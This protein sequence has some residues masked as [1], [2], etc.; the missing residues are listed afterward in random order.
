[1]A[2]GSGVLS[3]VLFEA[4]QFKILTRHFFL[5]LFRND[6]VD[7]E[8]QMKERVIGILALLAVFSGLLAYVGLEKYLYTPD[9]GRSWIEKL[10][11][12]TFFMLIMGLVSILEWEVIYPDRRDL[13]NLGPLP[14]KPR[15]F[16]AAKFGSLIIFVGLFALSLN[17]LSSPFFVLLLPQW[18]SSSIFFFLGHA[19]V[20]FLVMFLA[21]FFGFLVPIFIL[22]FLQKLMGPR[23]FSRVSSYLRSLLLIGQTF[24]ILTYLRILVYGLNNL[25]V[26]KQ[27]RSDFS[28]AG[29]FFD[30]FPPFWFTDLYETVLGRP[31]LPFHGRY[32]Y[33]LAGLVLMMAVFILTMG[34]TY[35][36]SLRRIEVVGRP[37]L[38]SLHRLLETV[39]NGLFLRNPVE[40]A[41]FHFFRKTLKLSPFHK[42]RL[43]SFLACGIALVPFLITIKTVQKD[44]LFA[45]N[46]TMLS[47]PLILSFAL[48][49]G[50]RAVINVPVSLEANW[51]FRLTEKYATRPY[52]SG[53]RKAVFLLYLVPLFVL[54][55]ALYVVL[56]DPLTAIRHCLYGLTVSVLVMEVFFFRFLK[57][58]FACAYLPGKEKIQSYW[59]IYLIGF[60]A[61]L[62][63]ASR[64]ELELLRSPSDFIYFYGVAFLVFIGIR[65]YQVFFLY[66]RNRIQYE[67]Q[68]EPVMIG[69]DYKAPPHKDSPLND[70]PSTKDI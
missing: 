56:W 57:I 38:R 29:R 68:L 16:L 26:I 44:D 13:S 32:M 69:L 59:F 58:P 20:H 47:I 52:F 24:L 28:K 62:K 64:I 4:R 54:L 27:L 8:D 14:L 43:A 63:I 7:F 61:Y 11:I 12:I 50:L 15:T 9:E 66:K 1:M 55:F 49:L 10:Y 51:A 37:R 33:A 31:R 46:T 53:L 36:R 60:I 25:T 45:L 3:S 42:T 5:R 23:L 18:R 70:F 35:G 48:L 19:I 2:A 67:E 40:S 65:T 21:C 17:L 6:L 30:Y 39:F 34:I 41:V 22:G